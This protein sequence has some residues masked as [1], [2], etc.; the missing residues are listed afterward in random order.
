MIGDEMK[1]FANQGHGDDM[2]IHNRI[3][4]ESSRCVTEIDCDVS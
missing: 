3:S 4:H 1:F 2:K